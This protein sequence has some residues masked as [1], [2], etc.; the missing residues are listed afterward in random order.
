MAANGD[1]PRHHP[2]LKDLA[3][4]PLGIPNRPAPLLTR[5]LLFIGEGSNAVIGTP[6]VEW[7]WGKKFRA[8]DKATGAVVWGNRAA[9]RD[10]RRT[11]EYMHK[12]K[13]YIVIPVGARD[14]PAEFVALG[15]P[16]AKQT[17]AGSR[18]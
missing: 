12:G 8:Y 2:L 3:L 1:G 6:Q 13:Q 7:A 11:D 9:V 18:K 10:D 4:P 14:H 17:S 5:T 15:F 16:D